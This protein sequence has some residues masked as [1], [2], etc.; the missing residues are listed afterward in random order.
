MSPLRYN[1]FVMR[2]ASFI[3]G[4][5]SAKSYSDL[6]C[7]D[8]LGSEYGTQYDIGP[9][10]GPAGS[11]SALYVTL[12]ECYDNSRMAVCLSSFA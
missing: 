12:P 9:T 5:V 10:G 3:N 4:S 6:Y 7:Q 8:Y 11:F 1:N 2:Y